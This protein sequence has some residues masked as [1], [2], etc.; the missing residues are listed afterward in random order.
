VF[1]IGTVMRAVNLLR[2][3]EE[4]YLGYTL[5]E[6]NPHIAQAAYEWSRG[7]SFS[8]L[9]EYT[10]VDEGDLVYAMRRGIDILQQ[11]RSAAREDAALAAKLSE[12]IKR[13]DRDEVSILL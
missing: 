2:K 11:V 9:A 10:D 7:A 1:D 6:F 8:A 12:C 13:M 5:L 4:L 3:M